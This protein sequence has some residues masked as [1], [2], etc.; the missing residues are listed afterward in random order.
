MY[1]FH[2]DSTPNLPDLCTKERIHKY[3]FINRSNS[4]HSANLWHDLPYIKY[5][6]YDRNKMK[7]EDIFKK[8]NIMNTILLMTVK[9]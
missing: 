5:I 8:K 6:S 9:E 3:P 2:L 1:F 7:N 4:C